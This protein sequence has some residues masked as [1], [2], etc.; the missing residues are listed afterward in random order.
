MPWGVVATKYTL[1]I[2]RGGRLNCPVELGIFV[3]WI[4]RKAECV[5]ARSRRP[6]VGSGG[7]MVARVS[8]QSGP[9]LSPMEWAVQAIVL[10]RESH[11]S[12]VLIARLKMDDSIMIRRET[13][14]PHLLWYYIGRPV[15]K[16]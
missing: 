2:W 14:E 4:A 1:K 11:P 15:C 5:Y 16:V 3:K 12:N 13:V 6:D 9:V 10:P 8:T 7:W